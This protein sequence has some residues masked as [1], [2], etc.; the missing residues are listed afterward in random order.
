[1][2]SI[3][4]RTTQNVTIEYDLASLRERIFAFVID[5]VIVWVI[6]MILVGIVSGLTGDILGADYFS[7]IFLRFFLPVWGFIFYQFASEALANGQSW[8]KKVMGL[9]VVRL[10]GREPGL[11]D[12]LLRAIFHIVDTGLSLGVLAALLVSSSTKKQ[13]LGDMTANTTV[14]RLKQNLRF[15][16]ADILKINTLDDYEPQ[17]PA[18]RNL[19]E[20]DMLLIKNAI[21]R[22]RE[23]QNPAHAEVIRDMASHLTKILDLKEE[24]KNKIEF[25]KTLS[26]DYIVLTR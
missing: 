18:V 8:G 15:R 9:K 7:L 1:M 5:L 23:F 22:Y 12:Y 4:I 26:R 19:S 21:A 17:Y 3:E 14:I 13:R 11:S 10:D 16:L 25:L 20:R 24:P 2:Q 6:C